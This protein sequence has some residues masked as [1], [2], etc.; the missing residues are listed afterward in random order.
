MKKLSALIAGGM[1]LLL[2][3]C[4]STTPDP[5]S[6]NG[7]PAAPGEASVVK[8]AH[9]PSTLFAPVYIAAAKG[10]YTEAGLDVQLEAVKSGQDAIPLLASGK[11]DALAAGFSAGMFNA[12]HE[13]LEFQIV[14]SMGVNTGDPENSPTMLLGAKQ[15]SDDG[16]VA[17]LVDLKGKKIAAAGGP[18]ATGG[19]L[20]A[21]ILAAEGLTLNDV[22]IVNLATPDMPNALETGAVAAALA[23]APVSGRIVADGLGVVLGVPAE[24]VGSSGLMFGPEFAKG[25]AAQKFFDATA[26]GAADL[27]GDGI[28]DKENLKILA[29]ATSQE[30]DA[31]KAVP[32]YR[33]DAKLAPQTETITQMEEIWMTGGQLSY[34]E[35]LDMTKL[36]NEAF[37]QN[38]A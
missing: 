34:T 29:E 14:G 31:L 2:A 10:Y 27:Q 38:V 12:M 25:D 28:S 8:V 1:A 23:S 33:Y 11:L 19:F 4:G 15:F 30:L 26:R 37:S 21:S 3:A 5:G 17:T 18:G 36:V 35:P 9:L 16:S 7:D 20:T 24:G 6:T 13:G 22:E 32:L